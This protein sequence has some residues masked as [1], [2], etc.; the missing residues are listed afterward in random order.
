MKARL[1]KS[2]LIP[3]W[4]RSRGRSTENIVPFSLHTESRIELTASKPSRQPQFS[5]WRIFPLI[6]V[7]IFLMHAPLLRLP[8]FWDEA[9]FYVPAAYDLAHSHTLIAKTTIDT[10]H[11]PLS[12]AY[13]AVWFT[14]SGWKPAVARIAMLLLAAFALTNVFLLARRLTRT[15]VA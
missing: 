15:S 9:G 4:P 8:F 1:A 12:A 10:G 11:P 2:S 6:F 5:A 3:D 14:L 13:L 7:A